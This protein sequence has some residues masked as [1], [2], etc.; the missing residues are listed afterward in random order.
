MRNFIMRLFF[1]TEQYGTKM[2]ILF[3]WDVPGRVKMNGF[4]EKSFSQ[5]E[6]LTREKR[7]FLGSTMGSTL[8]TPQT[9][10]R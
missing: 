7:Q 6:G 3:F 4:S 1:H 10:V 5:R 2:I 8:S 9:S